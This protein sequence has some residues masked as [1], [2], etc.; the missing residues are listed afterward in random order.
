MFAGGFDLDA[1]EAVG[2]TGGIEVPDVAG[3]LGSLVDKSLVMAEPAGQTLRYRLL[4]TIRQYAAE[5]LAEVGDQAAAAKGHCAYFLG[6]AEAAAPL[7]AGPEQGQWLAR[8][9]ADYANMRHAAEYAARDPDGTAQSLRFSVALHRYWLARSRERAALALLLPA[10]ERPGAGADP[11]LFAAALI[12]VTAVSVFVDLAPARQA[13]QQAVELARELHDDRLLIFALSALS[14][15]YSFLGE[16]GPGLLT[17]Q[18]AVERARQLGDDVL[19]GESLMSYLLSG[20]AG[21]LIEPDEF[22]Q[23]LA[24]ATACTER[25]GD[26]LIHYALH[27]NAGVH[28]L[29]AGDIPAARAHLEQAAHA[30]R[31]TGMETAALTGNLGWVR[32]EEGDLDGA[33]SMFETSLRISHRN[34][35]TPGMGYATLGLACLAADLGH[36]DR[37]AALHAIAQG[38]LDRSGQ[39]WQDPEARYR[40]DSLTQLRA[41]LSDERFDQSYREGMTLPADEALRSALGRTPRPSSPVTR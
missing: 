21:D 17:G 1:V 31:A 10:L 6:V 34:G 19:L 29:T 13:G 40:H 23:L 27:N 37:A 24:E 12:T 28:A 35:E 7:L 30:A 25:S 14:A 16:T 4:E 41:H 5:R 22:G 39:P 11:A 3:L 9:D 38:F 8:L 36:W 18:E 20:L 2:G 26:Q 15:A 32:R 33:L